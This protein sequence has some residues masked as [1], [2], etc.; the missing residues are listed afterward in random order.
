[1]KNNYIVG[2]FRSL[3][4]KALFCSKHVIEPYPFVGTISFLYE[5]WFR[6]QPKK[7]HL[8]VNSNQRW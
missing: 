5:H 4:T 3:K 7:N 6:Q 8:M 2:L 1:M